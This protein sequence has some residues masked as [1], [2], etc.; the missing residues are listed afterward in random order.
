[1]TTVTSSHPPIAVEQLANLLAELTD[2]QSELLSLLD[3][4]RKRMV[5]RDTSG[6]LAAQAKEEE[7]CQR[8]ESIQQRRQAMLE[9]AESQGL[10]HNNLQQLA[11]ALP[12]GSKVARDAK[13][14]AAR[15]RVLQQQSLTNWVLA[16]RSLLH[17]AQVME[18]VAT[19]GRLMPTYGE[20]TGVN[21]RGNLVDDAG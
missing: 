10:P 15:M 7:L 19:G 17:I 12:A 4:K 18:F 14:A 11:K 1:M 9:L 5:A 20:G 21:D 2:V 3:E 6:M 16:Q 13:N 8:L